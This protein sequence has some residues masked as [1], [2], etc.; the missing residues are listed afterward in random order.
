MKKFYSLLIVFIVTG[1]VNA[2]NYNPSRAG[3]MLILPVDSINFYT[4][5]VPESNYIVNG[6]VLQI[7]SGEEIFIEVETDS[8]KIVSMKCVEEIV[9]PN[10]T[11]VVNLSQKIEGKINKGS[12]LKISNPFDY[13]LSYNAAMYIVGGTDWLSTTTMPVEAN[14]TNFELWPEV[15]ITLV[16]NNWV[17]SE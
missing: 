2:Q 15:V 1:S 3:F 5:Q 7:Y 12:T 11:L 14:L 13:K 16:L 9:D 10:K 8:A 4:Q 6:T 17:L